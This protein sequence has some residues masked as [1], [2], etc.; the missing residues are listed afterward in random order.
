MI[1]GKSHVNN[2]KLEANGKGSIRQQLRLTFAVVFIAV[3][4]LI[5][6]AYLVMLRINSQYDMAV[7][8]ILQTNRIL[9]SLDEKL[10]KESEY[11]AFSRTTV[12][13]TQLL[14][15]VDEVKDAILNLS[16]TANTGAGKNQ[17]DVVKR[18]LDNIERDAHVLIDQVNAKETHDER[19]KTLLNIRL[20]KDWIVTSM[21]NYVSTEISYMESVNQQLRTGVRLALA[22]GIAV[23]LA[24]LAFILSRYLRIRHSITGP[25]DALMQ[26]FRQV[27]RGD[28]ALE[29]SGQM[30]NELQVLDREFG[31]M[32]GRLDH[33]MFLEKEKSNQLRQMEIRLLQE[34]INPHF[35]YNTLETIITEVELGHK[36]ETVDLVK[37]FS[38]FFRLSLSAGAAVVSLKE[39]IDHV[40]QY[41]LIQSRR[42]RDILSFH[43]EEDPSAA[44]CLIPK[45]SLQPLVEN[46]IYHGIKGQRKAGTI[47]IRTAL[48][49]EL[50]HV[51]ISV[52][53]NG[54]GMTETQLSKLRERLE[55]SSHV[56]PITEQ[57]VFSI[58][59]KMDEFTVQIEKDL[60]GSNYGLLNI[61]NR[62]RLYYGQEYGIVVESVAGQGTLVRLSI[63]AVYR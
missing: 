53:D 18:A 8:Q 10:I 5:A 63:C 32:A 59:E 14:V 12:E 42:Y 47:I 30:S 56:P 3:T 39:E 20:T 55:K 2:I 1:I 38:R 26:K 49:K 19:V 36:S 11:L 31:E 43:I 25:I 16:S 35:L 40:R 46:A 54:K 50:E 23:I 60:E 41:L 9:T 21:Q 57:D 34:Q 58:P 51:E 7:Q 33:L 61:Q 22:I 44:T 6:A 15:H 45:L 13:T 48:N 17:L 29:R 28:F 24:L 4:L 62:L 37:A 52:L 27:G